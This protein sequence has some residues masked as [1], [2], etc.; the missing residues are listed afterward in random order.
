MMAHYGKFSGVKN[1]VAIIGAK[2]SDL[3][4]KCGYYGEKIVLKAQ[5]M[6]LNTCWVAITYKKI[7]AAFQIDAG[8]ICVW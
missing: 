4:E 6:K 2:S 7:K 5:Q 1:Y 3:E 8:K